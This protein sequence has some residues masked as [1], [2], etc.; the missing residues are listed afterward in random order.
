MPY[1]IQTKDGIKI[2]NIPDDVAPDSDQLKQRVAAERQKLGKSSP[3]QQPSALQQSGDVPYSQEQTAALGPQYTPPAKPER[4]MGDRVQG[5]IEALGT[6]ATGATGGTLGYLAGTGQGL[7]ESVG[8]GQFGTPEGGQLMAQRAQEGASRMTYKPV[9]EAGQEYAQAIGEAA[10]PL[11]ALTPL[12]GE[13]SGVSN[14]MAQ[15]NAAKVPGRAGAARELINE[16]LNRV[17]NE[18]KL[19]PMQAGA[20]NTEF[21]RRV[22][23]PV[24]EGAM[25]AG[26]RNTEFVRRVNAPVTESASKAQIRQAM[27]EGTKDAAEFTLD[28]SGRV[29]AD[30]VA[31]KAISNGFDP[32][33]VSTIKFGSDADKAS[34]LKM[35]DMAEQTLKSGTARVRNRPQ[36]VIGDGIMRRFDIISKA[37]K[38]AAGDIKTAVATELKGKPVNVSTAVDNFDNALARL[39]VGVDETGKLSFKGSQLEGNKATAAITRVYNRLKAEDDG[40]N[41]H[42]L[43]QYIDSQI[44][45]GKSPD[46]PLDAQAV[47]ALKSLRGDIN[48]ALKKSS[49]KY[50]DANN[51][52]ST[53]I[54]AI[55][56]F[57]DVMGRRF[58]PESPRVEAL[59]GQE[60]RKVLSNYGV[61]NDMIS[62]VDKLDDVA[63]GF[64]GKFND[65]PLNQVVFYSDLERL[66]GSFADNSMQGTIE[67]GAGVAIKGATQGA[68]ATAI[69]LIRSGVKSAMS[70]SQE[71]A[72]ASMREMLQQKMKGSAPKGRT[73]S[74]NLVKPKVK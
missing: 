34:M 5:G 28:K 44:E 32:R 65:D 6:V 21:V 12:A 58:D 72:I 48:E 24:A 62:A 70:P 18:P 46:K 13:I 53:A 59:V 37:K 22:N 63:R 50:A 68:T 38:A 2:N 1:S 27:V 30:P 67:K 39:N 52:Y 74:L 42:M 60:L 73:P 36:E 9:G 19:E 41:L 31:K 69:D 66:L 10:A 71:K 8:S 26:S 23:A 25:Q 29:V 64:G 40:G 51:R 61:R 45:W 11:A 7:I 57:G 17:Q 43:K 33:T 3:V 35:L 4:T 20:R 56:D 47:S 15:Y 16:K 54:G 49:G 55:N 14:M